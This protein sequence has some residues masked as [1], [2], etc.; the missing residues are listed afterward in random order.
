MQKLIVVIVKRYWNQTTLQEIV[1][2]MPHFGNAFIYIKLFVTR[3]TIKLHTHSNSF[4]YAKGGRVRSFG[5]FIRSWQTT[6]QASSFS[7]EQPP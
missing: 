1:D 4:R 6:K 3:E 2:A 7:S 5:G